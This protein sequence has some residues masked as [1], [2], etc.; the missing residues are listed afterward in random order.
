[1]AGVGEIHDT[2]LLVIIFSGKLGTYLSFIPL[3]KTP[4]PECCLPADHAAQLALTKNSCSNFWDRL[5]RVSVVILPQ[6][7]AW[8]ELEEMTAGSEWEAKVAQQ[9]KQVLR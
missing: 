1:M 3:K 7:K 2:Q 4:P 5:E 9:W 6:G 8:V